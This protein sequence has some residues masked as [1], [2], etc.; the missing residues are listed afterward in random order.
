VG[1]GVNRYGY[2]HGGPAIKSDTSGLADV[3]FTP[4]GIEKILQSPNTHQLVIRGSA[5]ASLQ[6][7]VQDAK[8]DT[9]VEV[10][11][12]GITAG[13]RDPILF[14]GTVSGT[15][16]KVAATGQE[17]RAK[18]SNKAASENS[19]R[20]NG[21]QSK[22][23]VAPEV[24][25]HSHAGLPIPSSVVL[26]PDGEL[27]GDENA[28]LQADPTKVVVFLVVSDRANARGQHEVA[29]VIRGVI[30]E[31]VRV[32]HVAAE[33]RD[34]SLQTTIDHLRGALPSQTKIV[35]LYGYLTEGASSVT[36][37]EVFLP[38]TSAPDGPP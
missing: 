12:T 25:I 13:K 17:A 36:F 27:G 18:A 38:H 32:P 30:P 21:K 1:D 20:D 26:R 37:T 22:Y 35:G 16:A 24:S 28:I 23:S 8:R 4:E 11:A 10:G 3:D 7:V 33:N 6:A 29:V 5:L 19:T 31:G 14:G 2:C 34:S 15:E 9:S